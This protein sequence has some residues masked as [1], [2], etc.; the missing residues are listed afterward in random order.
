MVVII[1]KNNSDTSEK[2]PRKKEKMMC[3]RLGQLLD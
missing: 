3:P 1:I 2:D